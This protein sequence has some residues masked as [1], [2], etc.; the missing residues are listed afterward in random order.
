MLERKLT[1]RETIKNARPSTRKPRVKQ[2]GALD[3]R[4]ISL[5]ALQEEYTVV[6]S[7][8]QV[9]SREI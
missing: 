2:M 8:V 7:V 1:F 4:T 9:T 5:D 3:P 6:P